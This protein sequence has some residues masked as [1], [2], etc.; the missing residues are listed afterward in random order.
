M[1]RKS[2]GRPATKKRV[3]NP[4]AKRKV[5]GKVKREPGTLVYVKGN[6]DVI[7]APLRKGGTKGAKHC[8]S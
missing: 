4:N 3:Q 1:K 8:K 7:Q 2:P 5:I 6:G